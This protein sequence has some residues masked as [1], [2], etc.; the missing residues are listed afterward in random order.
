MSAQKSDW[1]YFWWYGIICLTNA[2][3]VAFAIHKDRPAWLVVIYCAAFLV[4]LFGL[5]TCRSLRF[6][7]G[8]LLRSLMG[9]P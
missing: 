8:L 6:W 1:R 2:F 5:F 3:N 4:G 9:K 7:L